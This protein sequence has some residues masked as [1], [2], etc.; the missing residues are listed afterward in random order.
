MFRKRWA[1]LAA[2][3]LASSTAARENQALDP[4]VERS[5]TRWLNKVSAARAAPTP[6]L[7]SDVERELFRRGQ[8]GQA[9]RNALIE[10]TGALSPADRSAAWNAI[11][12]E[13]QAIDRANLAYV[14]SALPADGWFHRS[15][16]GEIAADRAWLVV[17]HSLDWDFKRQVLERMTVLLPAGEVRPSAYALFFDRLALHDGRSQRYGTQTECRNGRVVMSKAEEPDRLDKRR[18][19]VGLEPIAEYMDRFEAQRC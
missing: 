16:D 13:V 6:R 18:A 12:T 15:R 14:K 4:V 2:V 5:L 1:A 19:S 10:I 11:M 17:H 3:A 7:G 8:I 9:A